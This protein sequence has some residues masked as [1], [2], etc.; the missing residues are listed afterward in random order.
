MWT[1]EMD[2]VADMAKQGIVS[3]TIRAGDEIVV[4]GNPARDGSNA[5]F[6][7]TLHRPADEFEYEEDWPLSA[8]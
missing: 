2:D 1:L 8:E 6:I 4:V 5:L 3:G 7:R